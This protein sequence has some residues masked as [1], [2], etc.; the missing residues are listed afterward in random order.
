MAP[1][2][3]GTKYSPLEEYLKGQRQEITE[4]PMTFEEVEKIIDDKLPPAAFKHRPWWSNNPS[5]STITNA[6]L[7]AGFKTERV[8]MEGHRLVFRRVATAESEPAIPGRQPAPRKPQSY[9]VELRHPL[10]GALKGTI[11]LIPG[12][13][14][15]QPADPT[16]SEL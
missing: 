6:W 8:H 9:A 15:T 14:L 13:D 7:N 2:H 3:A 4:I 11:R 12:D 10:F 5:N 1:K 16:W